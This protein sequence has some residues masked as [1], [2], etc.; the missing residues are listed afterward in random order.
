VKPEV[1]RVKDKYEHYYKKESDVDT[2]NK[3]A[4]SE[5]ILQEE[6]DERKVSNSTNSMK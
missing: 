5:R 2:L 4:I 1:E 6:M 3:A